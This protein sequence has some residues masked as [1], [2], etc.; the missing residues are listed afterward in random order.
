MSP[1]VVDRRD[2]DATV[3]ARPSPA[4][5]LCMLAAFVG[6]GAIVTRLV[7]YQQYSAVGLLG[8][9]VAL[10]IATEALHESLHAAALR[11]YG[12]RAEIRWRH[13]AVYP[14]GER[15]PRRELLVAAA[16]PV[17]A[18]S[19]AAAA[20]LSLVD[21][22][23]LAAAAGYVLVVNGTVSVL[24]VGTAIRLLQ[25]PSG[26]MLDFDGP[27]LAREALDPGGTEAGHRDRR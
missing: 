13:L 6:T 18:V 16:T 9:A 1:E 19:I 26:S 12:Y 14:V 5:E 7:D 25:Y 4:T 22:P 3:F 20:V 11:R 23:L 27:D 24:D 21:R 2:A 10:T 15:I 8:S 17:V